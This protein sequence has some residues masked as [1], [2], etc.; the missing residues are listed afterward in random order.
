MSSYYVNEEIKQCVRV[1]SEEGRADYLRMDMNENPEGLPKEFV[2]SVLAEITPEVLATYPEPGHFCRKYAAYLGVEPE[3]VCAV[4]GS[5]T[6]IRYLMETFVEKGHKVVTV[7]PTF[8]MYRVYCNM[9]GYEH[10]G[11][12]YG[13]DFQISVESILGQIDERTDMVVLL[14]PNNPI[15]RAFTEEEVTDIIEKA[16]ECGAMVVIDEAYHYFYPHTFLPLIHRYDHVVLLRTFSKLFSLAGCR[17]GVV[18][19]PKEVIEYVNHVRSSAEVNTVALLFGERLM[20]RPELIDQLIQ[21]EKEG[22]QYLLEQLEKNGYSYWNQ[23]GNFL[24]IQPKTEAKEVARRLKEE[25]HVLIKT[26]GNPLLRPYIRISTGSRQ[27][28]EKFIEAFLKV[29]R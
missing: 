24:F 19:G 1:F 13:E 22:R 11:V 14:N 15:G 23:E 18:I 4:S 28:M 20:D 3:E 6:G 25:E 27:A 17:L 10:V 5:D 21:T 7:T 8:E 29:D 9:F 16:G 26:Y 2:D 12:P